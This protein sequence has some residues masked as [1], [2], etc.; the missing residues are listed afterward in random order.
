MP[1]Y[2]V[3]VINQTFTACNEHELPSLE[4]ARQ[5]GVK[6]ALAIGSDEVTKGKAYFGAEVRV[7]EGNKTIVRFVVS[8]GSS[9]LQ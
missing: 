5:Q 4:A 3:T 1:T 6:A 2:R 8:V 7:Q 9:Q